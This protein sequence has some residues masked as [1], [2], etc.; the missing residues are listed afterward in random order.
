MA[1][2]SVDARHK[3]RA[4]LCGQGIRSHSFFPCFD[5]SLHS[6]QDFYNT[7]VSGL[8]LFQTFVGVCDGEASGLSIRCV[9]KGYHECPFKVN[10]GEIFYAF[11]KR[12]EGGNELK[13]ANDQGQL[14]HLQI[15]LFSPLWLLHEKITVQV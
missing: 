10:I 12:G 14:G 2:G 5:N 6:Q 11:Q 1:R 4:Y 13:V 15:A 7:P 9:A 3:S 8:H